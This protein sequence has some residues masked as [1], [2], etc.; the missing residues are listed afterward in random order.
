M[1]RKQTADYRNIAVPRETWVRISHLA[2]D[3]GIKVSEITDMLLQLF[4][5]ANADYKPGQPLKHAR[6][7][8]KDQDARSRR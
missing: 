2:L 1:R 6:F 7:T 3:S 8:R 5:T 4:C